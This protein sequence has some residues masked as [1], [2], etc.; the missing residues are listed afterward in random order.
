MNA[1]QLADQLS[2]D[3]AFGAQ[4]TAWK[5][6]SRRKPRY[7]EWPHRVTHPLRKALATHG[8][9]R[10]YTHQAAAITRIFEGKDVCIV[11]GT[12][13]GKT[14]C[15]NAPVIQTILDDPTACALYLF[16]T[17]ALAQDQLSELHTLI[18]TAK[19]DIKTFTYDGDT[20]PTARRA[21]R[22]AGHIVITNP[23]M[24]HQGILPH[25]TSWARLFENLTHV[26]V[27]E[28]HVY[29]GIFGSH[30][31]NVFRRLQRV[32]EFYGSKPQFICCSATIAN[33]KELG[34]GLT[35]RNLS[36]VDNDGSPAGEKHIILYNPPV[37]N[38][39]LGLRASAQDTT[40]SLARRILRNDIQTLVFT[41]SR[42]DTEL[43][44]SKIRQ[45]PNVGQNEI[46][47]YRGGY[48]PAERRSIES[49]LRDGSV[50]GVV[51][52]NAL[53]LGVD[54]GQ[55]QA[56][57]ISGYPGKPVATI[58]SSRTST[59]VVHSSIHRWFQ[60]LRSIHCSEP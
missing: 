26:I 44:L 4:V 22:R 13:S 8:I 36:I 6:Q 14:L 19:V 52:T 33:P 12:A 51:S 25:H 47:G 2:R 42:T 17:K 49:G 30:L 10:P 53:E 7:A 54:I 58:G 39:Q 59:R 55:L 57:L 16:P 20:S 9:D 38:Q 37:V 35:D 3:S 60:S 43:L 34:D 48:L 21:V 56:V 24:L 41:R 32:A 11:T 40:V 28:L 46:R 50:R 1:T 31:G 18:Q 29:R 27:D 5:V 23:D 15:Y 45:Q